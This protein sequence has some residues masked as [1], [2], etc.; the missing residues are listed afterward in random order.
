VT[1]LDVLVLGGGP[2]G[3]AAAIG[4]AQGGLSVSIATRA[5]P[6]GDRFGESLSP[7]AGPLL[8]RLGA[9][10]GFV[11]DGHLPCHANASAWGGPEIAYHDFLRDP[12]GHGW[13]VDRAVFEQRLLARAEAAGARVIHVASPARWAREGGVWW[14]PALPGVRAQWIVDATGRAASLARANGA[15]WGT[16]WEQVA[17]AAMASTRD[18]IALPTLV[19]AAPEGF[20][21]SAPVPGKRL[22]IMLFTDAGLLDA[23]RA[24]TE[25]GFLG[26]ARLAAHTA[27]RLE[28]T[29]A[30]LTSAPR[31]LPAGS[32]RLSRVFGEGWIAAGDAAM[33]YDPVS[34]HGLT[35]AL[36]SGIDAAAAIPGGR[37]EALR[38]YAE[39]L[40][41]AF[42][43]YRRE[44]LRIYRS[45]LRWRDEPYWARRH[46]LADEEG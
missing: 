20:W 24:T 42:A 22:V 27:G 6:P 4:L 13:H 44:A 19:E 25:E 8:R 45:E 28:S 29:G 14:S 39:V 11:A 41:R 7:A 31:F 3:S 36:R 46:A 9:W 17:L 23:R 30:R 5:A 40:D 15:S 10:D 32:G 21:Y 18:E 33:A 38:G 12:R 16:A 26:L 2:A 34:A 43:S 37:D 1:A 35:L